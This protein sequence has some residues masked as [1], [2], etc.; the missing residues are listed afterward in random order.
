MR[1]I[2]Q[3]S[4]SNF[5]GYK[6]IGE[7]ME[8]KIE[9]RRRFIFG[10]ALG[11]TGIVSGFLFSNNLLA[12]LVFS[13]E[14]SNLLSF[15]PSIWVEITK[16][17]KIIVTNSRAELGQGSRTIVAMIIVEE[18]DANWADM[19]VVQAPGDTKY[20]NQSTGG[21]TTVRDLWNPLRTAAAQ[22]KAMLITAAAQ[23]WGTPEQNCYAENG[24]VKQKN[25]TLQLSYGELIDKAS[26]L[27]IPPSSSV[28]L[29]SHTE[30][31]I[32]GKKSFPNFDEHQIVTGKVI[33]S[34]DYRTDGMK[35]ATIV[36]CPY[37]GGSLVSY[38][39]TETRKVKGVIATY[40][41]S[42]GIAI[43]A[44]NSWAA[45]EGKNK[46]K[47][48]WKQ[49]SSGLFSSDD[50]SKAFY[51]KSGNLPA[52]PENTKKIVEAIYEV[53]FIAHATMEPMA[54]FAH[55]KNGRCE[56]FAGTQN[57]QSARSGVAGALGISQD[58]VTIN[59]LLSGGGF[60]RRHDND[61]IVIAAK[62][63]K[64]SG[65]PISFFYTR[66]DDLKHDNHR[67]ASLHSVKSGIDQNGK[68][69]GWIHKVVSQGSVSAT[70]PTYD[71][72]NVNNLRDSRNFGVRTG[73]WRAVDNTQVNFVN[74]CLMDELAIL[75][76]RDPYQFRYEL[77]KDNRLKNVLKIVA[78]R[79]KWGTPLPKGWGR[80]IAAFIGYG[81]YIAHVIEVS[82]SEAGKIKVHKVYAVV[83]P[84]L[85]LNPEG[86]K[87]QLIGGAI[88]GLSTALISEITIKNGQIEQS[89]FHNF[90]WLTMEETPEFDIEILQT[91]TTPSG[92]GEV[93]FPSVS[94]ALCNAIYDASGVRIRKLPIS[95][96]NLASYKEKKIPDNSVE[97][98]AYPIPFDE[99]VTVV[100]KLLDYSENKLHIEISDV[101]GKKV[102]E[103]T[104]YSDNNEFIA[105]FNF[106]NIAAGSYTVQFKKGSKYYNYSIIKK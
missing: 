44:D 35:Y 69:T 18:L 87:N 86:I 91:S 31:K 53:Q 34:A 24:Y 57:P 77:A 11:I 80:G 74:E 62:I 97:F 102:N 52:L 85:G 60:G 21:S 28:K 46:L 27:P 68:P 75:A 8:K 3:N 30:Y 70:N 81:A 15:S 38:D 17:N 42:E 82:V 64:A 83:D 63:S 23:T 49:G 4:R 48:N 94:P 20:G 51:E 9:S 76:Q 84:G 56:V 14:K 89:G 5:I 25:G 78:E 95:K 33:Y 26:K 54:A 1:N 13:D 104:V 98:S 50:I 39:D 96:T 106:S 72:P 71:I 29:K 88:D 105:T 90:R 2:S 103:A 40:Q 10:S 36:R 47:S 16:D 58:N 66:E 93:G 79:S 99:T 22:A 41:I 7:E 92:M 12:E 101:L 59:V 100:I 73:P 55:F 32:L 45:L 65:Y 19:V 43:V 6:A 61:Y 67:P 37:I